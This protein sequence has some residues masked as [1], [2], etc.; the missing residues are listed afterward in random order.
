MSRSP[1]LCEGSRSR[2]SDINLPK[3]PR[4]SRQ[5]PRTFLAFKGRSLVVA[6][7]NQAPIVHAL[8]HAI[9]AA[10]GN[11]GQTVV[12][13]DPLSP[14]SEK[15]QVEQFKNLSAISTATE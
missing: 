3:M 8:A 9:N 12:Y 4:G 14:G 5:W 11:A 13:I 1:K 2:W 10:L 15:T 7:D 6:G